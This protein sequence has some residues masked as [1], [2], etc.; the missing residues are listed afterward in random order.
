[1]KIVLISFISR[2]GSTLLAN[3]L[4]KDFRFC[5]CPEAE[6]LTYE[7]LLS[8]NENLTDKKYRRLDR[9]VKTNNKLK[10]WN[11]KLP[12]FREDISNVGFF[13]HIVGEYQKQN[14]PRATFIVFKSEKLENFDV[15]IHNDFY[16]LILIRDPRAVFLSQKSSKASFGNVVM[17]KN[18]IRISHKTD[19]IYLSYKENIKGEL[20]LKFEDYICQPERENQRLANFLE[21]DKFNEN[22]NKKLIDD[23]PEQ[24]K[25]LHKNVGDKIN[26]SVLNKW[27]SKLTKYEI[28]SIENNCSVFLLAGYEKTIKEKQINNLKYLLYY[29]NL[30]KNDLGNKLTKAK[31]KL[32]RTNEL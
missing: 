18:P 9:A 7:L 32:F 24:Q 2:S 28:Y 29:I 31:I 13:T 14:N 11:I 4:S 16:K 3:N 1:M 5:V 22:A 8:P 19:R 17:N 6:I 21:I 26:L 30:L 25:H 10:H 27:K 23:L 20:L 15:S 12:P